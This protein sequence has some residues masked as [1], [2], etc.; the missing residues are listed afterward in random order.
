M[1]NHI[2]ELNRIID[3]QFAELE[4]DYAAVVAESQAKTVQRE[5]DRQN[6]AYFPISTKSFQGQVLTAVKRTTATVNGQDFYTVKINTV[7]YINGENVLSPYDAIPAVRY[8]P[9]LNQWE[10]CNSKGER[11]SKGLTRKHVE[12]IESVVR[13]VDTV[14]LWGNKASDYISRDNAAAIVSTYAATY[15]PATPR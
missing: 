9:T 4:R 6:R 5:I 2:D 1:A 13:K 10:S 15:T 11:T 14:S 8:N 7:A 12:L 3:S